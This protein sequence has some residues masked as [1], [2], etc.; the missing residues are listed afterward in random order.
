MGDQG[1]TTRSTWLRFISVVVLIAL[2][3][4]ASLILIQVRSSRSVTAQVEWLNEPTSP[5]LLTSLPPKL[6]PVAPPRLGAPACTTDKWS[7][8]A[9]RP[10]GIS[11]DDG[12]MIS[13]RNTGSSACLLEGTPRVVASSPG[14]AI[15]LA[16]KENLPSYGEV[17]DTA[18][19][20]TVELEID[21][22]A[23]CQTYPGDTSA[24]LPEYQ[25]LSIS[26]PS[27]M[28]KIVHKPHLTLPCGMATTPFFTP[29]PAPTYPQNPLVGLVPR[30]RLPATV[31]AGAT[32]FYVVALTNPASKSVVLSPC[33][34]YLENS[35]IPTKLV[36]RL[37][38]HSVRTIPAH[39]Q[40]TYQMEMAVPT[41]APSGMTKVGWILFGASTFVGHGQVRV[42]R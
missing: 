33:P 27:G 11:Q 30:L 9:I 4:G 7:V 23:S 17:T 3:V 32:L 28:S 13:L 10:L 18:P 22:P 35:S 14:K 24:A 19:G 2:L 15:V 8:V 1:G 21:I 36:Y 42:I 34:A 37:N 39:G 25:G 26:M 29:T 16:S 12:F 40:V 6:L 41:T 5:A 20:A 31:R 38:C